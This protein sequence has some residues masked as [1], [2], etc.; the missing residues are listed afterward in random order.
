MSKAAAVGLFRI[1]RVFADVDASVQPSRRRHPHDRRAQTGV[2]RTWEDFSAVGRAPI[3]AGLMEWEEESVALP[4]A[5]ESVLLVGSGPGRDLVA[6]VERGYRV[7]ASNPRG[8]PT[9]GA[10]APCHTPADRAD[11]E[12]FFEDVTLDGRFDAVIFSY[13]CYSFIPDSRR[14][15]RRSVKR[16]TT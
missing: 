3:A 6:L 13:C 1:G 14:R 12:G 11:L 16:A 5:T 4:A 7:T 10:A 8:A 2:E 9:D 15:S